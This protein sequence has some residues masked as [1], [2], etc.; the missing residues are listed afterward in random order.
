MRQVIGHNL[1]L[2]ALSP[3][4]SYKLASEEEILV[5]KPDSRSPESPL[6]WCIKRSKLHSENGVSRTTKT[7]HAAH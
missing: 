6:I 3:Q 7:E 2:V 1:K 5:L 4:F